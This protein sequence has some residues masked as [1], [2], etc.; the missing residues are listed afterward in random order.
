MSRQPVAGV[1]GRDGSV[2]KINNVILPKCSVFFF[3][4]FQCKSYSLR[5]AEAEAE[6][7]VAKKI[8]SN[9]CQY[10]QSLCCD[11]GGELVRRRCRDLDR[12]LIP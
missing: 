12:A 8:E 1:M 6:E 7:N 3:A 11:K 5:L 10:L 4:Q 9:E 2:A